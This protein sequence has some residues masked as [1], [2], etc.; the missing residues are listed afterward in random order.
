MEVVTAVRDIEPYI[1]DVTFED[2]ARRRVDVA[3][4][5]HKPVF[6]PLRDPSVFAAVSVD[7]VLGPVVWHNGADLAPEFLS[8]GPEAPPPGYFDPQHE[9]EDVDADGHEVGQQAPL[10]GQLPSPR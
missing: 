4:V 7:P 1:L 8:W 3:P 10:A 6:A 9:S 2:G 5:L